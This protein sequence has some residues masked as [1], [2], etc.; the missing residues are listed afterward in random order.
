MLSKPRPSSPG[1]GVRGALRL[2]QVSILDAMDEAANVFRVLDER[3][4]LESNA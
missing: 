3:I 2:V 4:D 1:V